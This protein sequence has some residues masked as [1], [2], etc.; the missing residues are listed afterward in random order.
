[1]AG[2]GTTRGTR[3]AALAGAMMLA[4]A[5]GALAAGPVSG[6]TARGMMLSTEGTTV[7][8][9]D[10]G[11]SAKDKAT[12]KVLFRQQ[13]FPYYGAVAI[14]P[15]DGLVSKATNAAQDLHSPAAAHA[16][17]LAAC[18]KARTA[19]T[20]CVVVADIVPR[21]Y[22]PQPLTL[23]VEATK[24]MA[25]YRAMRGPK[26]MAISPATNAWAVARGQG[27]EATAR[28]AC[29][30]KAGPLGAKDCEVVIRDN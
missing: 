6:N 23:N 27:A 24:E 4:A 5:G 15:G 26:A 1:M 2:N 22:K 28:E 14:S 13:S 17:A 18:N 8:R 21:N 29:N 12:L 9:D 7:I 25:K 19:S 30:R 11:L 10:A 20:P 16:A 3:A